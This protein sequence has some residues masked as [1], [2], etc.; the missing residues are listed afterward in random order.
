[1]RR[2]ARGY[3]SS[4]AV[5]AA[6]KRA[7]HTRPILMGCIALSYLASIVAAS[8]VGAYSWVWLPLPVAG[9]VHLLILVVNARYIRALELLVHDGG[10]KNWWRA[11]PVWNH[12]LTNWLAGSWVCS[13]VTAYAQGHNGFHHGG[14]GSP[15]DPDL[16]R[17]NALG[18][19]DWD[20]SALSPFVKGLLIRLPRYIGSYYR[21]IGAT[22]RTLATFFGF[23]SIFCLLPLAVLS[24]P[25]MA[26]ALWG[27]FWGLAMSGPLQ[28]IRLIG[29]AEEHVYRRGQTEFDTTVTNV[30]WLHHWLIHPY[31][32]GYHLLHHLFPAIPEFRHKRFHRLLCE[33]DPH[34]YGSRYLCRTRV[35]QEP[36]RAA[37]VTRGL[38]RVP[39]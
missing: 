16:A 29:E 24:T 5:L 15:V 8:A 28:V 6:V 39:A 21:A 9:A 30:G 25:A 11:S 18:I 36:R 20:R 12:R 2:W 38:N 13:D 31:Q 33:L 3:H 35:V 37:E 26:L 22:P 4:P 27:G 10:H 19:E 32:D 1:M 7:S 17:Y 23:H 34:G 14:Y